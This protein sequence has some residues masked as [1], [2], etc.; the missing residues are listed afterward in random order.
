M[1]LDSPVSFHRLSFVP[2]GEDVLVGRP[3]TDDFAV[4]P[5]DG[6]A[7]LRRMTEGYTPAQAAAWYA[8]HYGEQL[9]MADFLD[10]L[11]ELGFV[12]GADEAQEVAPEV[13]F[14]RLAQVLFSRPALCCY[15][16]LVAAWLA[17]I[18]T[19]PDLAPHPGQVFYTDSLLL[20]QLVVVFGQLPFVGLHEAFHVL[21]GRR[22]G[23]P[24]ELGMG[25]RLYI[26]VFETRMNGLLTV[27]RRKRY[28]PF[29]A[30]ILVDLVVVSTLG[31]VAFALRAPDGAEP[32]AG[33]LLLAMA[34]PILIRCGY[35]LFLFLE[36]D[37]YYV[38]ATA[39]GCHDLHAATRALVLNRLRRVIGSPARVDL[40]QWTER[41]LAVARWYAPFFTVGVAV[42]LAMAPLVFVPLFVQTVRLLADGISSAGSGLPFWDSLVFAA[43]NI[44]QIAFWAWLTVRVHLRRRRTSRGVPS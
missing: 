38:F 20:V 3:D 13:R 39:L 29:L 44:V 6:A 16:L 41:D 11:G 8:E 25:T 30:G 36:T 42:L 40:S 27:E 14:Q 22:L 21:A 4:L 2:D 35:Q 43:L 37:V 5:P 26:V 33:R 28:L 12:R 10:T 32:V 31:L 19:T 7:A 17:V 1:L 15:G 34:F 18:A 23:L 9:D 24:S